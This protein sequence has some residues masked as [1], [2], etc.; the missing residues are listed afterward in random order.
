MWIY[1]FN[2]GIQSLPQVG[3]KEYGKLMPF[4]SASDH[5]GHIW[6]LLIA[7]FL[8]SYFCYSLCHVWFF[9]TPWTLACQAPQSMRFPGPEYWSEVAI[10]FSRGSSQ[11]LNPSLLGLLHWQADPISLAPPGKPPHWLLAVIIYHHGYYPGSAVVKDPP[12]NAR[13][14]GSIPGLGTRI[15]HATGQLSPCA[16]TTEA[17]T[18]MLHN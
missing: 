7:Y 9:V 2:R 8:L 10:Y 5:N 12:A 16:T 4:L 1:H 17:C 3:N 11:G 13:D 15:P 18:P 14:T 6:L